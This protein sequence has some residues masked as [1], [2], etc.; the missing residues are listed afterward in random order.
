[1]S[2]K[3]LAGSGLGSFSTKKNLEA[4]QV[5][6]PEFN[7]E[8]MEDV[9]FMNAM[10]LITL[11]NYAQTGHFGGPLAYTP[12]NVAIHL[13][14]PQLGAMRYDIRAPKHPYADKFMLA[15]GHCIPT[16]YALWM[17]LYQ[18]LLNQFEAT[19]DEKFKFDPRIAVL[20]IDALGFRR[21][22][23]ACATLLQENGLADHP[24]FAQ[25]SLRGIRALAGHAE[26][27]D[28]TND[29]NG[30]PSGVGVSTAAGKAMFWDAIGADDQLKVLAF[31]G[32]FAFTEGHA[33][34]LKTAA[35]AQQVGKRLRVL[36][37]MNNSGIDDLLLGG[38]VRDTYDYDLPSQWSSY[39]WNVF[40]LADGND[41]NQIFAALKTMEDWDGADRR[42]M[43]LIGQ[44]LKGWWPA[45]QNGQIPGFGEQIVDFASHPYGFEMNDA[46]F[47]ALATTFETRYDVKFQGLGDGAPETEA[48]RLIQFKTNLDVI[49]SVMEK[50]AGLRE[51]IAG[52]LLDSAEKLDR[53]M[54]LSIPTDANPFD[55]PRLKVENLPIDPIQASCR[56]HRTGEEAVREVTLF[57]PPGIKKGARQGLS[58]IGAYL[59]HVTGNRL[60][61]VAADL[62]NSINIEKSNFWGHYDPLE[63]PGGTR[64][65][66]GI[67]EAVNAATICG[68]AGQSASTDPDIHAGVWGWSGTYG[69][70]TPLMY[71]PVRIHSQQN[72]DS[73]FEL[74][75]VTVIAG[76][77]GPETAAD[78]R[79]HFGVFAPQVWTLFPKGQ[80]CNLYFWDYNDV[81]AGYFAAVDAALNNKNLG[82]LVIHV[83]R[84]DFIVADR[85]NWAD[86]E[87]KSA[88]KGCYLIRDW[89]PAKPACGTVFVQGSSA[90]NNL[91]G[92]MDRLDADDLNVRI[93]AVISEDLF[94]LQP[95]AYRQA[96]LPDAQRFDCMVVTT[97]TKR[98]MPLAN[99][100]P[101][102][103]EYTLASDH[104]DRWRTGG[105]EPDIIAEAKLDPES[106]YQG[107][108]RFVDERESRLGRQREALG[109][110]G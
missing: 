101:L 79:S 69:A 52:Q 94:N 66:A 33:Q 6:L 28:A 18:A 17:V 2:E 93:V 57:L 36:L 48:E 106:I 64:V 3:T 78:A 30:G 5:D 34:E 80:V 1:M 87:L 107:V 27:T 29:V 39:G 60:Y 20:P 74:G 77:S 7:Q 44:T 12:Y 110:L 25:A 98:V 22:A 92:L 99:L 67:Y 47:Q 81:A 58:E 35:L 32:E 54:A 40:T 11:G 105:L 8:F 95:A 83:A 4:L 49:M 100:G 16:C 59:N 89:D 37:S 42:P 97:M 24:L 61:T 9:G 51:W 75:V 50:K 65:K 104:D 109:A 15:G 13:G 84:P 56:N 108:K 38:V 46:Y 31:E 26:T 62:S 70:F 91:V 43:V 73:P 63:N 45:A 10:A 103:E 21:S 68:L 96:I 53:N 76:H 71:L 90:S 23:G 55:D 102:T 82:V 14:G 85:S 86:P 19:G 88:A 72:Q 41:Y